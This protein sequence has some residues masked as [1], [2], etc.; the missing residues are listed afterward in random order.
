[1]SD[2]PYNSSEK[3]L[4]V[5]RSETLLSI[6]YRIGFVIGAFALWFHGGM[7][8]VLYRES[9]E[10]SE[11]MAIPAIGSVFWPL[12]MWKCAGWSQRP[13]GRQRT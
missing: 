12:L 2:D 1:M 6:V 11:P 9:G 7:L 8:M 4:S 5:F 3:G 10:F 13:S